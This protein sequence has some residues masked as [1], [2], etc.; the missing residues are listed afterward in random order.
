MSD[1]LVPITA[2][3]GTNIDVT[4]VTTGAGTVERQRMQI[5]GNAG[6]DVAPVDAD[7]G[8][9]TLLNDMSASLRDILIALQRP[10]YID[11]VGR[12]RVALENSANL[13][14][15]TAV[16]TITNPV[17]S[18]ILSSG[19]DSQNSLGYYGGLSAW[20]NSVRSTIS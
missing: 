16:T 5:G 2:G 17:K 12:T 1:Q 4:E 15:V 19:I 9:Y 6:A 10:P 20:S 18:E 7:S 3:S 13:G 14:T 11:G 8:L